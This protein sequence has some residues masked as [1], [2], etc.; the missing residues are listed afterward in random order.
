MTS[1]CGE[2]TV[3]PEQRGVERFRQRD[4]DGVICR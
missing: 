3:A 1:C 2:T 4:V